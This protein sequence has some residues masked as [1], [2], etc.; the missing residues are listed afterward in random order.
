MT[1]PDPYSRDVIALAAAIP[2]L[3]RLDAPHVTVRKVSRLCGS[4]VTLD[5]NLADGR[6]SEIG[7]DVSACALGQSS[8]SILGSVIIGADRHLLA[9]GL[10]TL[11]ALLKGTPVP[12]NSPFRALRVLEPAAQYP[13]RHGSIRLAFEAALEAFDRA[14]A[15]ER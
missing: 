4:Q 5:M 3:K 7:W 12:D 2:H 8:A 13:A 1:T 14:A 10:D 11:N 15:R 6:V 9:E